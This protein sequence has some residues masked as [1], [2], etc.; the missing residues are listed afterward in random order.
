MIRVTIPIH[1]RATT[2]RPTAAAISAA[3]VLEAVHLVE[4]AT[5]VVPLAEVAMAVAVTV[6]APSEV[7]DIKL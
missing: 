2:P 4:A 3:H 1:R 5:A 6:E 7:E